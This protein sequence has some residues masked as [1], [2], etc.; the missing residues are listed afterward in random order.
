MVD[1]GT[2]LFGLNS[3]AYSQLVAALSADATVTSTLGSSFLSTG[4]CEAVQ[5]TKAQ[6]DAMLPPLTLTFGTGA[7]AIAVVATAT[8][9]YLYYAGGQDWCAGIFDVGNNFGAADLGAAVLKSN[10]VVFDRANSQIGF[11]PKAPCQ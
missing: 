6:L 4:G 1:T 2:S 5:Q 7:S 9:S 10:V 11:A 8:D 3:N